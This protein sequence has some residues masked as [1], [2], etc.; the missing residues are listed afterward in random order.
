VQGADQPGLRFPC[1]FPIK[2][3]GKAEAGFEELVVQI[4]RRHVPNLGE[5]A[6]TRRLSRGGKYLAVTLVVEAHRQAQLDA[7]YQALSSHE[8]VLM[9]L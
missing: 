5:G 4:V 8:K 2:A 3:M 7:V 6:V 1:R 9:T